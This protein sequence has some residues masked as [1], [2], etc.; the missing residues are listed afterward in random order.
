MKEIYPFQVWWA[1]LFLG[2]IIFVT[3]P[4]FMS[5][6]GKISLATYVG[7]TS[8]AMVLGAILSIPTFTL[9][10][11][12]FK[13]LIKLNWPTMILKSSLSIIAILCMITTFRFV[14]G[15]QINMSDSRIFF[16]YTAG[17]IISGFIF[18]IRNTEKVLHS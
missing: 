13:G 16:D 6:Y 2:P 14:F 3:H 7:V 12:L 17:I 10:F 5:S 1:S 8:Y 4:L 11:V 18:R 15:I 9:Y